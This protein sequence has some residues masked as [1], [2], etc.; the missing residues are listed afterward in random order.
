M[1]PDENGYYL[2]PLFSKGESR[3]GHSY[4][5]VAKAIRK[6]FE[7]GPIPVT[8]GPVPDNI[9]D[10]SIVDISRICGVI[11][12][13]KFLEESEIIQGLFKPSPSTQKFIDD[14]LSPQPPSFSIRQGS[15]RFGIRGQ[16]S[17]DSNGK[18]Q[19]DRIISIDLLPE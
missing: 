9:R 18:L 11:K 14:L 19:L 10:A 2:V 8:M 13:P 5:G 17:H 12:E 1:K 4:D 3:L 6:A 16:A 7:R 15:P